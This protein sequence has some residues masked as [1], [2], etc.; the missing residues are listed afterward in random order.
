M[1][2]G[3]AAGLVVSF[4]MQIAFSHRLKHWPDTGPAETY[5]TPFFCKLCD[6]PS[7]HD[8][9]ALCSGVIYTPHLQSALS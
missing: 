6:G 2:Y 8:I 9:S 5:P 1:Q 7:P 4:S 3:N